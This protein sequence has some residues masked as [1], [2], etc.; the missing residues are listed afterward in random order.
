MFNIV[1]LLKCLVVLIALM[2]IIPTDPDIGE[3]SYLIHG[4]YTIDDRRIEYGE[5]TYLKTN[6]TKAVMYVYKEADGKL[7]NTYSFSSG[8]FDSFAY[9]AD[10]GN[11]KVVLVCEQYEYSGDNS[12][13]NLKHIILF[14]FD[15]DG[16]LIDNVIIEGLPIAYGNFNKRLA[17]EYRN[18]YYEFYDDSLQE[19]ESCGIKE[20]YLGHL[21]LQYIGKA[22]VNNDLS[23]DLDIK[24]PG[25]YNIKIINGRFDYRFSIIIEADVYFDGNGTKG[26]YKG[27]LKIYSLGN[28]YINDEPYKTGDVLDIPGNY[29]LKIIGINGYV[30]DIAFVIEPTVRIYNNDKTKMLEDNDEF[31]YPINIYSNAQSMY[32]NDEPYTT[33]TIDVPGEYHLTLSGFNGYQKVIDFSIKPSVT[34]IEDNGEYDIVDL[35][36]FGE[37]YLNDDPISGN[38]TVKEP[39]E[40]VLKLIYEDNV[41]KKYTFTILSKTENEQGD[42]GK[43]VN[44]IKYVF[45]IVIGFG[46]YIILRKK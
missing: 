32:L 15:T 29:D 9:L 40:Y 39:G 24:E 2:V 46:F 44:Y 3:T 45:F 21:N 6:I 16:A 35:D 22:Y 43:I 17:L 36:V 34:G 26:I 30:K 20:S 10:V 23:E 18:D 41:Y 5:I 13:K 1:S 11:H 33:K 38:K 27:D 4:T 42:E 28:L 12:V 19:Y 8:S 25:I 37:A 14:E 7:L 31:D